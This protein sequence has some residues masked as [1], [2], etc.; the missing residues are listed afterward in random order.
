MKQNITVAQLKELS[1]KGLTKLRKWCEEKKYGNLLAYSA[2]HLLPNAKF[3]VEIPLLSIGQM[4]EFL[5]GNFIN[6]W[7]GERKDWLIVLNNETHIVKD[8]LCD[9]LWEAC[10][11][12]LNDE[13]RQY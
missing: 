4:I 7:R 9:A 2:R 6:F 1:E 13:R 3:D 11:I 12:I 8:E 5:D 10:L